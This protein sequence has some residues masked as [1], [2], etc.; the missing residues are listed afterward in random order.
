MLFQKFCTEQLMSCKQILE[1]G[2]I[3]LK[4]CSRIQVLLEKR[5]L[6]HSTPFYLIKTVVKITI[7]KLS[8]N[9][10]EDNDFV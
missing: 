6:K 5:I 7:L 10:I 1:K 4:C 3:L 8:M 9:C 2:N